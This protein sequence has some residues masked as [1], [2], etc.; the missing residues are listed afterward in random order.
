MVY[1]SQ[2]SCKVVTVESLATGKVVIQGGYLR[3]EEAW[4][5]NR[6]E[7]IDGRPF[8]KFFKTN[9]GLGRFCNKN[10]IY[11]KF[12]DDILNWRNE[13]CAEAIDSANAEGD[14]S[15]GDRN[16][17]RKAKRD[18]SHESMLDT[19]S[20]WLPNH[21]G[22]G[23]VELIFGF[24]INK[25][26]APSL[27]ISP[28]ALAFVAQGI[29]TDPAESQKGRKRSHDHRVKLSSST[30]RWNYE[31]ASA[32]IVYQD[33]DG[34]EH[35]KHDKPGVNESPEASVARLLSFHGEHHRGHAVDEG[36]I[37][38]IEADSNPFE[39]DLGPQAGEVEADS[40]PVEDDLGPQ[41]RAVGADSCPSTASF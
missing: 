7:L 40:N 23:H 22:T 8:V 9:R 18:L 38:A 16:T 27:L 35:K 30:V 6:I 10:L 15:G 20:I 41:D 24:E 3:D 29:H 26:Y 5:P 39:D 2:E 1:V 31:R 37:G 14:A 28:E 19:V 36:M 17:P 11:N 33:A 34:R 13:A 12:L 32:Y 4:V 21:D 25:A